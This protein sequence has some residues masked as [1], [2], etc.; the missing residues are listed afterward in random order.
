MKQVEVLSDAVLVEVEGKRQLC[1]AI[2]F[3]AKGGYLVSYLD[4][5]GVE[6]KVEPLYKSQFKDRVKAKDDIILVVSKYMDG[7]IKEIIGYTTDE[8]EAK[9]KVKELNKTVVKGESH[10]Y[11]TEAIARISRKGS[12]DV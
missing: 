8:K 5:N 2:L 7:E 6:I 9:K 4:N 12:N 11:T 10:H 3:S 1:K